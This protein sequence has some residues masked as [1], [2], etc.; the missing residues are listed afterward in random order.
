[1]AL[2]HVLIAMAL[3]GTSVHSMMLNMT[4]LNN[5]LNST[6]A[7]VMAQFDDEGLL[8]IYN[9]HPSAFVLDLPDYPLSECL[10]EQDANPHVT[11]LGLPI[12]DIELVGNPVPVANANG[13]W[14]IATMDYIQHAP[15]SDAGLSENDTDSDASRTAGNSYNSIDFYASSLVDY[16]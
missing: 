10:D 16:K 15:R 1:M 12:F 2:I 7:S 8:Y 4:E 3:C 5:C 13:V 6:V 11:Y 14:E 9:N